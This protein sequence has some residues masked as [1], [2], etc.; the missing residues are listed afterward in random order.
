MVLAVNGLKFLVNAG[1]PEPSMTRHWWP[2]FAVAVAVGVADAPVVIPAAATA[3][4]PTSP[5]AIRPE[6]RDRIGPLIPPPAFLS[7]PPYRR[8]G[9]THSNK[10][11]PAA[12]KARLAPWRR[13]AQAGPPRRLS[14][15]PGSI[16]GNG[17]QKVSDASRAR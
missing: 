10:P 2:A 12:P 8:G 3:T 6:R 15:P 4:A 13:R 5:A 17:Y 14:D 1:S 7:L 16:R 11:A 9:S